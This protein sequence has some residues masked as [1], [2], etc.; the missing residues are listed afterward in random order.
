MDTDKFSTYL[1]PLLKEPQFKVTPPWLILFLEFS[2]TLKKTLKTDLLLKELLKD[3]D[4][5]PM[6]NLLPELMVKFQ[7]LVPKLLISEELFSNYNSLVHLMKEAETPLKDKVT[8]LLNL[9][10]T[11]ELYVPLKI[12]NTNLTMQECLLKSLLPVTLFIY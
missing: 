2:M 10:L 8:M 5:P 9:W 12:T 4:L 11:K 7:V 6:T 3:K 1:L